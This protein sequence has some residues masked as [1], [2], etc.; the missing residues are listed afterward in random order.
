MF[1]VKKSTY[2]WTF[3]ISLISGLIITAVVIA[4]HSDIERVLNESG[5]SHT[6]S[7]FAPYLILLLCG[8][9]LISLTKSIAH[10]SWRIIASLLIIFMPFAVGF[11]LRPIYEDAIYIGGTDYAYNNDAL[12]DNHKLSIIVIPDCPFCKRAIQQ[13]GRFVSTGENGLV[14]VV[15]CSS[16]S[17]ATAKYSTL[18]PSGVQL[19]NASHP[20][21]VAIYTGGSFPAYC[22]R[23]S[24]RQMR[25][26]TNNEFGPRALDFIDME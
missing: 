22:N 2:G 6:Y 25:I 8:F 18:L 23:I 20:D 26:W 11:A 13:A 12:S 1:S 19:R 7:Y 3:F 17:A 5:F 24:E 14:E 4:L 10:K 15:L 16:D 9:A 21:S